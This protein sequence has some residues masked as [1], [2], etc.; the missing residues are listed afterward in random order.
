MLLKNISRAIFVVLSFGFLTL[1]ATP[2]FSFV[3]ET[4]KDIFIYFHC[5]PRVSKIGREWVRE[6]IP[7]D[8]RFNSVFIYGD[9]LWQCG[10]VLDYFCVKVLGLCEHARAC[11]FKVYYMVLRGETQ[12]H[13]SLL[14]DDET[15]KYKLD[16][17]DDEVSHE[18]IAL[19]PEVN[20]MNRHSLKGVS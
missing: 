1:D 15:G 5:N 13:L 7:S 19:I 10:V 14:K 8:R 20:V 11:D 4:G 2:G 9:K 12:F 17:S 18:R 6:Y 3:N 16:I